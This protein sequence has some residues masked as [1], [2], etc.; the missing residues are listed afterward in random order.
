M[1]KIFI[2]LFIFLFSSC[3]MQADEKSDQEIFY[4]DKLIEIKEIPDEKKINSSFIYNYDDACKDFEEYMNLDDCI[5]CRWKIWN[6]L[7]IKIIR[8]E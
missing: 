5:D 8:G 6:K 3:K 7:G 1:K 4:G 2:I